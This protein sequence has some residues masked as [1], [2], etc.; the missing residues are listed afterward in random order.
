MLITAWAPEISRSAPYDRFSIDLLDPVIMSGYPQ[1]PPEVVAALA[2]ENRSPIIIGIVAAFTGLGFV[3]VLLRFFSRSKLVGIVG[4]E[5]Y[6]IAISMVSISVFSDNQ[7][8]A[9]SSKVFSI[10]TSACLIQGARYGNGKHLI[11]LPMENATYI[12]KVRN[13]K[14]SGPWLS[15][16]HS[17]F[18]SV[19]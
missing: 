7:I 11:N 10:C 14:L 2:K 8:V 18:S 16:K 13:L 9:H 1:V 15:D 4:L 5:D 6:F 19:S 17:I 12:L 3:C